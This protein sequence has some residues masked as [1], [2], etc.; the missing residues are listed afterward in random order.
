MAI[1][2]ILFNTEMVE[3]I[4]DGRKTQTRRIIRP[5]YDNTHLEVQTNKYGT[6][7]VEIEN[8]VDG[9]HVIHNEDGTTTRKLLA[10]REVEPPYKPGDVLWV[11]ET[12]NYGFVESEYREYEPEPHW[13]EELDVG[14]DTAYFMTK[15]K[16][17]YY[18]NP[19]DRRDMNRLRGRWK[20]S[21]HMPK[22]A[23]RIWLRVIAIQPQRVQD[24][25]NDDAKAEGVTC[26]TDNSGMMHRHKFRLLWDSLYSGADAWK[27]NPWVWMIRFER[28]EPP[29]EE[30]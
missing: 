18:A 24:I 10:A 4:L 20:P 3:A 14:E 23:A 8:E 5:K 15:P 28:T 12:W 27:A 29:E 1:K 6:R 21:I 13:F 11:R 9:V 7:L 30:T 19:D 22:K 26:A 17:W 2:P 16:F 25:T